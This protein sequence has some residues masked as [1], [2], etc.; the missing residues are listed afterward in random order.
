MTMKFNAKHE[1]KQ[2]RIS[3]FGLWE[4]ENLRHDDGLVVTDTP[5]YEIL[6]I[7]PPS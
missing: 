3:I 4:K 1:Q 7:H 5:V 2:A 6:T